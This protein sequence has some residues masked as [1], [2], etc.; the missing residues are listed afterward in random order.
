MDSES[1]WREGEV[2][3][4]RANADGSFDFYIHYIN[5]NKRLDEWVTVGRLHRCSV[6]VK[7]QSRMFTV[8]R[9]MYNG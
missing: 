5:F 7:P 8:N 4:S 2:L 3:A 1:F 9:Y 6:K